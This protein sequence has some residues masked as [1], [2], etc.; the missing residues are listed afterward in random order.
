MSVSANEAICLHPAPWQEIAG[1]P[2]GVPPCHGYVRMPMN[3][4]SCLFQNTPKDSLI[5][6]QA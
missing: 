4:A 5:T 1:Q 2:F 6:I 3:H